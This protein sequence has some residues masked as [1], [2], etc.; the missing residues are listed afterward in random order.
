[1]RRLPDAPREQWQAWRVPRHCRRIEQ[2]LLVPANDIKGWVRLVKFHGVAQ[3]IMRSSGRTWDTGG[4][5][6]VDVFT[7]DVRRV[8]R[9]LQAHGWSAYGDPVDY[10]WGG[11]EVAQVVATG[12]DGLAIAVL[13]PKQP[14][15][16]RFPRYRGFSRVFN[17]SLMVRD[18]DATARWFRDVLGWK[19]MV[20]GDLQD[21]V[22]P[23]ERIFGLPRPL[24]RDT[25]RRCGIVHPQGLNDGSLETIAM[26]GLQGRDFSADCIA[27]NLGWLAWRFPVADAQAHAATLAGRGTELLAAPARLRI[28]PYGTVVAFSVR[29]PDGAILEF[30]ERAGRTQPALRS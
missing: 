12:P 16:A 10:G 9:A 5:F 29:T 15:Q 19:Y 11:F 26:P 2:W 4:I 30:F 20:E 21:V 17:S 3:R 8:Y 28:A 7:P 1:V 14:P 24:A 25:L 23:G 13:Q 18:Y 27:P 6:D 22:E